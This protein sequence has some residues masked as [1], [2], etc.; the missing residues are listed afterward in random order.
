[1]STE[2]R[3][4]AQWVQQTAEHTQPEAIHWCSGSEDEYQQLVEAMVATKTLFPLAAK[5]H[6]RSYLHRSD[7]TDVAR[8][9]HLTF[10]CTPEDEDAGPTN[11]W[12][13][14]QEARARVWPLFAKAMLQGRTMY[15]VPYLMGPVGLALQP[16]RSPAHRLALRRARTCAS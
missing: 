10:I 13:S 11:N 1:M 6:P 7:P 16:R 14:R 15:V 8:T 2:N 3:A 4:L 12:M 5:S 9:E